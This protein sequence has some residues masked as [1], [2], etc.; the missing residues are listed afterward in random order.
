MKIRIF[1]NRSGLMQANGQFYKGKKPINAYAQ[2]KQTDDRRAD[3]VRLLNSCADRAEELGIPKQDTV[4][5]RG[6]T[7]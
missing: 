6:G 7:K 5:L 3:M 1:L 4:S 2:I